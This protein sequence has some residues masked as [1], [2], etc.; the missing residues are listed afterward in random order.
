LWQWLAVIVAAVAILL[1]YNFTRL[2]WR[3]LP[4]LSLKASRPAN[5][6]PIDADSL[7][8]VLES[9]RGTP[10]DKVTRT[11]LRIRNG[12]PDRILLSLRVQRDSSS[13]GIRFQ[14]TEA[15]LDN[16]TGY[17]I[18][19][20][21]AE[22]NIWRDGRPIH[23]EPIRF[24]KINYTEPGRRQLS[25]NY[26]GDSISIHF[27]TIGSKAF[28]FCYSADKQSNYGNLNDRWFCR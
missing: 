25:G 2:Q 28:N 4:E 13:A 9:R 14:P 22:L 26:V 15:V 16:A 1:V 21:D 18:D 27:I 19:D 17:L 11:N 3:A 10:L 23:T 7:Q 8:A 24:E 20:A 12:W 5:A 6:P